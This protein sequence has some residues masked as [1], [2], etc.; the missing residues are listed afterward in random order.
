[1]AE[2]DPP[3]HVPHLSAGPKPSLTEVRPR[4]SAN[5]RATCGFTSPRRPSQARDGGMGSAVV[6]HVRSTLQYMY[7]RYSMYV[8]HNCC[9]EVSSPTTQKG[10]N[11]RLSVK[12]DMIYAGSGLL[13]VP[14]YHVRFYSLS[15]FLFPCAR[16][17]SPTTRDSI[18]DEPD[19]RKCCSV[20]LSPKVSIISSMTES[21]HYLIISSSHHFIL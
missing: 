20:T 1:M 7:P 13:S 21:S 5:G 11:H 17:D 8:R 2:S 12:G 18:S 14:F 9:S 6:G 3:S 10:T 4:R 19:K 15:S 16:S